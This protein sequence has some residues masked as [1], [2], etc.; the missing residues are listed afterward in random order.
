MRSSFKKEKRKGGGYK[1]DVT[2]KELQTFFKVLEWTKKN[3]VFPSEIQHCY[4]CRHESVCGRKGYELQTDTYEKQLKGL[5]MAKDCPHYD[6][7]NKRALQRK[8]AG[9]TRNE[10]EIFFIVLVEIKERESVPEG[11]PACSHCFHKEVCYR[12]I[13]THW[14]KVGGENLADFLR[15]WSCLYFSE[16]KK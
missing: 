16:M 9:I 7:G 3:Y 14:D 15:A 10:I 11:I 8:L 13:Y 6:L 1:M 12:R 5:L 4:N 2:K